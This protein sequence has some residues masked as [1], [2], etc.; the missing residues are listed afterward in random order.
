[1]SKHLHIISSDA[2]EGR[3]TGKKGQKMAA[4]YIANEFKNYGL[5]PVGDND[6]YFQHFKMNSYSVEDVVLKSKDGEFNEW[7]DFVY[8][9]RNLISYSFSILSIF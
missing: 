5:K 1:M 8:L 9:K 3:E 7:E 6:S 4:D 2:Y